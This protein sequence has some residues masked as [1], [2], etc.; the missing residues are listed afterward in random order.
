MATQVD[1]SMAL[2]ISD[3]NKTGSRGRSIRA[4]VFS[5]HCQRPKLV[6][7]FETA[8]VKILSKLLITKREQKF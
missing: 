7:V 8:E 5:A 3:C 6:F 1:L 2:S 4:R